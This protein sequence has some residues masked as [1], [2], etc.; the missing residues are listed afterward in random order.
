MKRTQA[1]LLNLITKPEARERLKAEREAIIAEPIDN[2]QVATIEDREKIQGAVDYFDE[3]ADESGL[4]LWIMA[5]NSISY[6]T[7]EAMAALTPSYILRVDKAF[8]AYAL[9]AMA[10]EAATT[11]E[12]INSIKVELSE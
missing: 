3:I 5:D 7:K 1:E 6:L 8:T 2:I 10:L 9:A 4:K 11:L 12:E